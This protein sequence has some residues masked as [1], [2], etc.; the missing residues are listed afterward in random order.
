MVEQLRI[1]TMCFRSN[2]HSALD[3]V[4]AMTRDWWVRVSVRTTLR[5]CWLR[6]GRFFG[7]LGMIKQD[8]AA[9]AFGVDPD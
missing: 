4:G 7:C 9:I 8:V 2:A 6:G 1:G 5:R 3:T